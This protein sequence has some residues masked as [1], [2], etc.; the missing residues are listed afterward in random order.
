M[1]VRSPLV[2]K[3]MLWDYVVVGTLLFIIMGTEQTEFRPLE[4]GMMV[5][6]LI[7]GAILFFQTCLRKTADIYQGFVFMTVFELLSI[8]AAIYYEDPIIIHLLFILIIITIAVY[9]NFQL[10]ELSLVVTFLQYLFYFGLVREEV[11]TIGIEV[12]R[13][14]WAAVGVMGSGVVLATIIGNEEKNRRVIRENRRT[15]LDMLKLV[16]M[17]KEEAEHMANVKSAFLANMSHE[18][19]TPINAVLGMNELILREANQ[20]DVLDY[21]YNIELAGKALLSIVNDILDISKI[22]SGKTELVSGEY[23]MATSIYNFIEMSRARAEK[24]GILLK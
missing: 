10:C 23:N 11:I 24:K 1:E 20:K 18:I 21:A 5:L 7:G 22:E 16:E 9:R 3:I 14:V 8:G 13:M 17:K 6:L 2:Q 19:R 15:S 4:I 12:Y